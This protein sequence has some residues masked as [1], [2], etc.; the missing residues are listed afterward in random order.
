MLLI[1]VILSVCITQH[2]QYSTGFVHGVLTTE[3]NLKLVSVCFSS[4][5]YFVLIFKPLGLYNLHRIL[6]SILVYT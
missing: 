2:A 6:H 4:I 5:N 1:R 3:L